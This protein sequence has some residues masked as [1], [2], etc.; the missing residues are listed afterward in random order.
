MAR[1]LFI[2]QCEGRGHLSQSMALAR[3]LEGQGH[4]VVAVYAGSEGMG[5]LPGYFREAFGDRLRTF[6]APVFL[7]LPNR[8]GIRV[9]A[10][11]GINLLRARRYLRAI[12][13]LR[14]AL[15]E[16]EP[17][18]VFNFYELVGALALRKAPPGIRRVA[19]GHHLF[20]HLQHYPCKGMPASRLLF[21]WLSRLILAS[22]DRAWALSYQSGEGREKI[23]VVPPLVRPDFLALPRKR[24][25]RL[26]AYFLEEGYVWALIAAA[27]RDPALRA[28][29]FVA[30]ATLE[31]IPGEQV[32]PGLRLHPLSG[33]GFR[34][35]LAR[36]RG[37][38]STSGFDSLAEAA[39][40]GV[41]VAV[42][43]SKGHFEQ[44]CNARDAEANGFAVVLDSLDRIPAEALPRFDPTPFRA[45]AGRW[46]EILARE[47]AGY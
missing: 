32:P 39:C 29:V 23:L 19:V 47:L 41:P 2:V 46:E 40:L 4:E 34:E 21:G 16:H 10:T 42:V 3:L 9:G 5:E 35:H 36:C 31:Q 6:A 45:W 30:P 37:L 24:G 20:L 27:H 8:Q 22:S 15:G 43:P 14:R 25:D 33:P 28:D 44:R 1:C 17:D 26:L 13:M 18:L 11:L 38:I 7:R 12:R